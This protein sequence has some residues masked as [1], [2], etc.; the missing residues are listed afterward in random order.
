MNL[1]H[2]EEEEKEVS[3]DV[4][5]NLMMRRSMIIPEKEEIPTKDS[6]NSWL[7]TNIFRT[8]CPSGGKVC[9]III[10]GGSCENMVSREMVEKL[11]LQ[12]EN[13]P[14][15]YHIAWFK[16]GNEVTIDKKMSSKVYHRKVL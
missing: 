8:R 10:D 13:H 12:C 9:Q 2:T 3:P 5:E 11:G 7:R 4:G 15:P 6:A 16:K 14:H 1:M